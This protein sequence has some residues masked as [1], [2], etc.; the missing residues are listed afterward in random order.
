[1]VGFGGCTAPQ[2]AIGFNTNT[3]S[4]PNN[5][6]WGGGPYTSI[7]DNG[8]VHY[9]TDDA[10]NYESGATGTSAVW[11]W[12]AGR[13]TTGTGGS[14]WMTLYNSNLGIGNSTPGYQLTLGGT[15][16]NF[17]VE[18]TATF[19]AKNTSG[20]YENYL[21]PRWSD[22][23]TYLNYGSGGFN[24]RNNGST[25]TMFM[26]NSNT[27]G[28]GTSSPTQGKLVVNGY[29]SS[30]IGCF[31]YYAFAGNCSLCSNYTAGYSCSGSDVSIYATNRIAASEF[32]AFSDARIKH[33]KDRSNNADDLATLNKLQVTDYTHRDVVG[34]GPDTK[35]GFI[36]QE[37]EKVFPE[38]V[39]LTTEFIPNVY[40]NAL[41]FEQMSDSKKL[42]VVMGFAPE[43]TAGDKVKFITSKGELIKTIDSVKGR[44]FIVNDWDNVESEFVFVFGKEVSDFRKV[45]YDRIHTLGV[46]AIQQLSKEVNDLKSENS[47]LKD[48]NAKLQEDFKSLKASVETL[49]QIVGAKAQK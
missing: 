35:K 13:S 3:T 32:D 15:G 28:I 17:G 1:M 12:A 14:A 40:N 20:T 9:Y 45:D 41:S 25:V 38:A 27:V 10:T 34:K 43:L 44:S 21:W 36:A 11:T 30:G 26:S 37:V 49:Q 18:N 47:S 42:K 6:A 7:Y 23:A 31:D 46:S 29:A 33:I 2:G 5:I 39:S 24:V 16:A 48:S 22:N 4:G 8:N 19:A